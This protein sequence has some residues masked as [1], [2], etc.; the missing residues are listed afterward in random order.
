MYGNI[1]SLWMLIVCCFSIMTGCAMQG[2]IS[3]KLPPVERPYLQ[4]LPP[5]LGPGEETIE[6]MLASGKNY[7]KKGEI[8][9][10]LDIFEDLYSMEPENPWVVYYLSRS[11]WKKGD[12]ETARGFAARARWLFAQDR[13]KCRM[14]M[15]QE[16]LCLKALGLTLEADELLRRAD[17]L[18]V[19]E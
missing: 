1:L 11:W 15:E 13:E 4:P 18:K 7:L 8:E 5:P 9:S 12:F 17:K 19:C 16:A 3:R 2:D 6:N 14:A 10:A